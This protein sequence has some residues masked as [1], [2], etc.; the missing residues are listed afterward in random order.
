MDK[1]QLKMK[2]ILT[3]LASEVR[4][5]G[6]KGS[7]QNFRKADGDFI[8]V[9][10][11]Q[12]SR[13]G[14]EFFINLG[15]QPIFIPT[16]GEQMPDS[17]KLKEYE[18]VFRLRVGEL[19]RWTMGKDEREELVAELGGTQRKFF[20]RAK[21]LLTAIEN[22]PPK[23]LLG[24]FCIGTTEARATLHLARA[25]VALGQREKA[26]QLVNRG[27]RLASDGASALRSQ[28]N[29]VLAKAS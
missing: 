2:E 23:F 24:E 21:R 25:C 27:L 11:F 9:I 6:F 18:C 13:W 19:H 20:E 17:K 14:D 7:G 10:N 4:K 26:V 12:K 16:E 28:L 15:A 5:L 1:P 3:R 22:D 8:F 29:T